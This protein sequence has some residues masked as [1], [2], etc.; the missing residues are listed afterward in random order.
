MRNFIIYLYP[1]VLDIIVSVGLFAGRHTFGEKGLSTGTVG[2]IG[3]IYGVVY[4]LSNF[5]MPKLITP[6]RAK[7]LMLVGVVLSAGFLMG[8]ANADKVLTVHLF[9]AGIP[10]SASL[11]FNSF[12]AYMLGVDTSTSKPAALDAFSQ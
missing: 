4:I 5:L 11:F 10:F 6:A 1:L 8:L 12:Q 2:S 9:F 7:K 3:I